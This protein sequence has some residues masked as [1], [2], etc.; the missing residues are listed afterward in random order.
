MATMITLTINEELSWCV[1]CAFRLWLLLAFGQSIT[2]STHLSDTLA[3]A[4][5]WR[6]INPELSYTG[7]AVKFTAW[8]YY[9]VSLSYMYKVSTWRGLQGVVTCVTTCPGHASQVS[10]ALLWKHC[11]CHWVCSEEAGLLLK[12]ENSCS[13]GGRKHRTE[14]ILSWSH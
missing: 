4:G 3:K 1:W 6:Q 5:D 7:L 10:V 2:V 11:Q 13:G 14:G 8:P 12:A 9:I